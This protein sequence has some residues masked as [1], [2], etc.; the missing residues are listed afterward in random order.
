MKKLCLFVAMLTILLTGWNQMETTEAAMETSTT[1]AQYAKEDEQFVLFI[2]RDYG[3]EFFD[4]KS[5]NTQNFTSANIAGKI[6]ENLTMYM[7]NKKSI[8]YVK[9]G[10]EIMVLSK[11]KEWAEVTVGKR[12]F[13]LRTEELEEVFEQTRFVYEVKTMNRK[14]LYMKENVAVMDVPNAEGKEIGTLECRQEVTAT[15]KTMTK[16]Q[17]DV[18]IQIDYNGGNGYVPMKLVSAMKPT[19]T[20]TP[21]PT[22]TSTP[23]PTPTSTPTPLPELSVKEKEAAA[24]KVAMEIADSILS[25]FPCESDW[26]KVNAA[27]VAVADFCSRCTYT[28]E[29]KDYREAYGVFV[30]G[31][32][33]CAG[34][35]RALG[36]V[37]ECMGYEWEHANPNQYTHQWCIVEIDGQAGWADGQ[38]GYA[39]YGVH[40]VSV[41]KALVIQANGTARAV[42]AEGNEIP[43]VP[44]VVPELDY[45]PEKIKKQIEDAIEAS[46]KKLFIIWKA[47]NSLRAES[48][49]YLE[50]E[51]SSQEEVMRDLNQVMKKAGLYTL[52][53]YFAITIQKEN[54]GEITYP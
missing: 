12:R 47:E 9:S 32:F 49:K 48:L 52:I 14:T 2:P 42:D 10:V 16:G 28:M 3:N 5:I 24:M 7:V 54:T 15:G 36:M 23:T 21:T 19:P 40:P 44:P 51:Y 20:S 22:P 38:T 41:G 43:N 31:E 17:K 25:S 53:E 39:G 26:V 27:S 11:S 37:L 13:F 4:R 8:G 50:S 6:S 29:G 35:T 45:N 33:S 34:A 1:A 30:K 18:W 46:G